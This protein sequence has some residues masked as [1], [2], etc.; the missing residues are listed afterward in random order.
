MAEIVGRVSRK[1][2]KFYYVDKNGSVIEMDR[3]EMTKKKKKG[4]CKKRR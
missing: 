2:S 4:K 1:K 3:S